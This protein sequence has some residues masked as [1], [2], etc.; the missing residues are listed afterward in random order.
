ME[1]FGDLGAGLFEDIGS[2]DCFR[3]YVSECGLSG[4]VSQDVL[5]IVKGYGFVVHDVWGGWMGPFIS[6]GQFPDRVAGAFGDLAIGG[7]GSECVHIEVLLARLFGWRFSCY[8][9][10]FQ[11]R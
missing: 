11:L 7:M 1:G 5:E 9:H 2:A 8:R 4:G 6:G 10:G 3:G